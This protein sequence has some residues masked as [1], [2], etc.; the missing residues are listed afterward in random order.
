MPEGM[1]VDI[2]SGEAIDEIHEGDR[3]VRKKSSEFLSDSVAV[4]NGAYFAKIYTHVLPYVI[5][6][7]SG[8]ECKLLLWL[9]PYLSHD[10]NILKCKNGVPVTREFIV[11]NVS[12][13]SRSAAEKALSGLCKQ[14]LLQSIKRPQGKIYIVNPWVFMNGKRVDKT[15]Y[16]IF[17]KSKWAKINSKL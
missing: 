3:I 7:L 6:G 9:L 1:V 5:E 12:G 17:Y 2:N 14:D 13:Y 10:S 8:S 4:N 11:T 16:D 15:C